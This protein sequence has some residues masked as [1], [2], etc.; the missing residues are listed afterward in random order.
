MGKKGRGRKTEVVKTESGP[1]GRD[2]ESEREGGRFERLRPLE[3][4]SSASEPVALWNSLDRTRVLLALRVELVHLL[5][6]PPERELDGRSGCR[7]AHG[8]R[9]RD[10]RIG[11]EHLVK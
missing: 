2:E 6:L 4:N 11:D 3:E 8:E 7:N 9:K 1:E 5:V 10:V